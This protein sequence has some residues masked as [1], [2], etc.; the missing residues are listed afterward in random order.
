MF[1]TNSKLILKLPFLLKISISYSE[2][3]TLVAEDP[4]VAAATPLAIEQIY[5]RR[6]F[7]VYC[8][9]GGGRL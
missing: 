3:D 9:L 4:A 2:L 1:N 7:T 5:Y 8:R 6:S